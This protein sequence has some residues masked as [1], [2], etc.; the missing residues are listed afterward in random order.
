M[1]TAD[2]NKQTNKQTNKQPGNFMSKM[3]GSQVEADLLVDPA[4]IACR[5]P[6]W[7]YPITILE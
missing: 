6:Y 5:C 2:K 3:L 7:N 4:H 1:S